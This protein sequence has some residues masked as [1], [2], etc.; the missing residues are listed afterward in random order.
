MLGALKHFF[1]GESQ[2]TTIGGLLSTSYVATDGETVTS[3]KL[4]ARYEW[5]VTS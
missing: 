5:P 3:L 2:A 4:D 1:H